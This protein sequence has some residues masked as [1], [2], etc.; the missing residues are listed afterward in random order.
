MTL[1]ATIFVS[2]S[3]NLDLHVFPFDPHAIHRQ[4]IDKHWTSFPPAGVDVEF[5]V[6][7][8][9]ANPG[10]LDVAEMELE[11]VVGA[12][13]TES[14]E[15]AVPLHDGNFLACEEIA[16]DLARLEVADSGD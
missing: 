11:I 3:F 16:P 6:M 14:V 13:V 9:T 7:D 4:I 12:A 15:A 10:V 1:Y 2:S 8:G 5:G